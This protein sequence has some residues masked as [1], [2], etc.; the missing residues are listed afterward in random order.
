MHVWEPGGSSGHRAR[1]KKE[2]EGRFLHM[3][4]REDE[5]F[6]RLVK[7][8]QGFVKALA[9]KLAPMPG[10]GEDIA[11]EVFLAFIQNKENWDLTRDV[12]P[13]LAKIT[14]NIALR[15][16]REKKRH[17]S[18]A[19]RK[20]AEHVR[21]LAED[22]E[23]EGESWDYVQRKKALRTCLEKLPARSRQIIEI[24]YYLGLTSGEI[25][26]RMAMTAEA[27][28]RALFRL[29]RALKRCIEGVLAGMNHA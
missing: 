17:M 16:W 18:P 4:Q 24:Y 20:L 2:N 1:R 21:M 8:H 23:D 26:E 13:L 6:E 29:R 19:F 27:V 9:V 28:R 7:E 5:E 3:N 25:G 11:Q 14:R 12:K 22:G 10:S 15:Y